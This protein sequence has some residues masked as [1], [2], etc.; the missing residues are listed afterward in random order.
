[1]IEKLLAVANFIYYFPKN[2]IQ[3]FKVEHR[4]ISREKSYIDDAYINTCKCGA[5]WFYPTGIE[6]ERWN[7]YAYQEEVSANKFGRDFPNIL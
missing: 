4:L 1:M 7:T 2:F 3:F 6:I 5:T